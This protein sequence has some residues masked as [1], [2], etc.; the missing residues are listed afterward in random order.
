[1]CKIYVFLQTKQLCL[2]FILNTVRKYILKK[3][4]VVLLA[5]VFIVFLIVNVKVIASLMSTHQP[6]MG[7]GG[8]VMVLN[9][10]F[11]Y[12]SYIVMVTFIG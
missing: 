9:A 8:I 2:Y 7:N 12:F 1:M 11:N 3:I 4:G 5:V 10:S 6:E